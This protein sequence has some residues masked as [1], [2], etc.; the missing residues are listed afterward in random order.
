MDE[1]PERVWSECVRAIWTRRT[2]RTS[3][4]LC[5][6]NISYTF[7]FFLFKKNPPPKIV[8]GV[9]QCAA[10]NNVSARL[11]SRTISTHTK[12]RAAGRAE[13][14]TPCCQIF[15]GRKTP[16]HSHCV[17]LSNRTT[18]THVFLKTGSQKEGMQLYLMLQMCCCCCCCVSGSQFLCVVFLPENV[19]FQKNVFFSWLT[20]SN[21]KGSMSQISCKRF[22]GIWLVCCKAI[23]LLHLNHITV[24]HIRIFA[25][26]VLKV[27]K[28][29]TLTPVWAAFRVS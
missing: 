22:L 6:Q 13:P 24:H 1:G 19:Y 10:E 3:R 21:R 23:W 9:F 25:M 29:A 28:L 26:L 20:S 8:L 14:P 5:S 27:M 11:V 7:F 18:S 4:I 17:L 12:P 15:A 2:W 16:L